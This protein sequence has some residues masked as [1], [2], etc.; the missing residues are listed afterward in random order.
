MLVIVLFLSLASQTIIKIYST[1]GTLALSEETR[2]DFEIIDYHTSSDDCYHIYANKA[3]DVVQLARSYGEEAHEHTDP[4]MTILEPAN[5]LKSSTFVFSTM[6]STTGNFEN[7]VHVTSLSADKD[8][9]LLDG[10]PL[11]QNLWVEMTTT[12]HAIARIGVSEGVHYLSHMTGKRFSAF[13]YGQRYRETYALPIQPVP[14]SYR[15]TPFAR[16]LDEA[17]AEI[18]CPNT[19]MPPSAGLQ[20]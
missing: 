1:D 7:T 2:E 15:F 8:G 13:L 11:S 16:T 14:G 4:F 5:F 10:A 3:I 19:T 6:Q 12:P 18:V 17:L 9:I 20:L